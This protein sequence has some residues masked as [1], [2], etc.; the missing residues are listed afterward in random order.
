FFALFA[1]VLGLDAVRRRCA[2]RP[3]ARAAFLGVLGLVLAAGLMDQTPRASITPTERVRP[4]FAHDAAFVRRV[5]AAVAP[6]SMIFQLPYALFPEQGALGDMGDY[7]LLR[8]YL[9]S[10]TLRWSY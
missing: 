10:R 2:R 9:H 6:Q 1:V 8:P 3:A 4:A 5:E 7:D